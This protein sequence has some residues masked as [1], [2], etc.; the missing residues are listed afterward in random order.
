MSINLHEGQSEVYEDLFVNQVCRFAVVNCS[1]GWGKSYMAAVAGVTA[2]FELLELEARIPNKIVYIIAPTY[3][4]VTDIY[5]P[6]IN[7]ELGMEN[8]ALRSSR[9]TG[10]FVFQNGVELRLLSYEAVE[11]MRGKG[12]YF[13]V[14][15][16]V[17]SCKKG[18]DPKEAWESVILPTI[19]TRWSGKRQIAFKAR[20]PGRALIISTPKGYNYFYELYNFQEL[21]KNWKGYHYDY[22]KSPFLDSDEI[23]K[24]RHNTDPI[25]FASEY[26]ASFTESGNSVFYCFD[27]KIHVRQDLEDFR[28][29]EDGEDF[30]EDVHV[31]I[32]FNVGLQCSSVFAVRGKQ[33][34][35][36]DEFKG[37]PDTETLAIA[38]AT[39]YKGHKIYA[40]PDPS[41]KARKSSAP[42]GRTDFSI[43]ESHGIRCLAHSKAPPI[44]DSVNAV[45]R[46][47]MNAAGEANFFIHPRCT[48]GIISLE[49]TKWVDKNPDT[50]TID[51]S[52]G[53]EHFSDGFRYGTEYLFPVRTGTRKVSRGFGF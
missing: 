44:I 45:N 31:D 5:Y 53:V 39:K 11:R 23:E 34:I 29:P 14:W 27:R 16:E 35:V 36:L 9:D 38:I 30:G 13:V 33:K 10:R 17:S 6:L 24:I 21:D 43:L 15:D 50:A 12:A 47:L 2:V 3:D 42:V 48:G 18:I 19:I 52:E 22:T 20:S 32:D 46:M 51:K 25:K 49:R 28:K 1:R 40:Y 4:Q 26:L 8:Y 41:G 37:H 7:Y